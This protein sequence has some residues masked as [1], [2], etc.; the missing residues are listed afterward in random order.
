[1]SSDEAG[2]GLAFGTALADLLE[3]DP[4]GPATIAA[5]LTYLA[6]GRPAVL[7]EWEPAGP[8]SPDAGR[9]LLT[10]AADLAADDVVGVLVPA[11][12]GL[13]MPAG[14]PVG[15]PAAV[16]SAAFAGQAAPAP[17]DY[18]ATAGRF[19]HTSV[20]YAGAGP[21]APAATEGFAVSIAAA[22]AL[23]GRLRAGES[24]LLRL[25]GFSQANR[26][27]AAFPTA[28]GPF[29]VAKWSQRAATLTLTAA[30]DVPAGAVTEVTIPGTA[31]IRLTRGTARPGP[32]GSL[33]SVL[34]HHASA[35]VAA[36]GRLRP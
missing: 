27:D 31:G 30:H 29:P 4:A 28:G 24:V 19:T 12:A 13:A 21:W 9:I 1:V 22:F 5:N 7:A 16:S 11:A 8:D 3:F 26:S 34:R 6:A 25:P 15:Y 23:S 33:F 20:R 2:A 32:R 17:L 35:P 10:A 14:I 18:V 36:G